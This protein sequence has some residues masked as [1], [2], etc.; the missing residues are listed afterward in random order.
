MNILFIHTI[1]DAPL[2]PARP[3]NSWSK[4][5]M[6]ISYISS[7]LKKGGHKTELLVLK[8]QGFKR[9]TKNILKKTLFHII[10][11]TA[12]FSDYS[13]VAEVALFLEMEEKHRKPYMVIGGPHA[14]LL[15]QEVI[16]GPFDA[17][18]VG[19]GEYAMVEL[20]SAVQ[21]RKQPRGIPNLWI[22]DGHS[23]E[24]NPPRE[25]IQNLDEL[26]FPDREMWRPWVRNDSKHTIL[27][28]RGCHYNCT[29]CC[30]HIYKKL[31]KGRYVRLR[32]QLNILKEIRYISENFPDVTEIFFEV[33][34]I[35]AN[36][37]WT[38]ELCQMLEEFN[39]FR[40]K[41][42]SFGANVRVLPK[43]N[44]EP[45]FEAFHRAGLKYINIGI[46][47][48]SE[49]LRNEVLKRFYSNEDVIR[50][51]DEA[52][53][54]GLRINAF[55]MVGIPGET[56]GDFKKTIE[57]NRRCLPEGNNLSIFFPYPG[58][59][60]HKKC[61]ERGLN[62]KFKNHDYFERKRPILG[63]PEFPDKL[64][65]HYF[66]WFDWYAFKGKRPLPKILLQVALRT[67]SDHPFLFRIYRFFSYWKPFSKL[68]H[69]T[70][71][72]H[73]MRNF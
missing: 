27:L 30:N 70:R 19:E 9:D 1:S 68:I 64:I 37:K 38:L 2:R 25:F 32:S 41:P 62:L 26:P 71:Y 69:L 56:P 22:K 7:M 61:M 40:E 12:V 35:M 44:L 20:A 5:Q 21:E 39:A 60:L 57:I 8:R 46:E 52:H 51:C 55:N 42:I 49:R 13:F 3:L 14:S 65:K 66:R 59:E 73:I 58:T 10:C 33:E 6:G 67:I 50:A 63:L 34:T 45:S 23:V 36:E 24:K 53:K 28:G 15:P 47:S 4:I 43:R 31:A 16:N 48:G 17:V 18:C 29:Y 54:S 72:K 11:F